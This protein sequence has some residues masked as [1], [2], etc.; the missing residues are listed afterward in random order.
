MKKTMVSTLALVFAAISLG[1]S[2]AP[3]EARPKHKTLAA[4]GARVAPAKPSAGKGRVRDGTR[5][6]RVSE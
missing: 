4:K 3:A 6:P 1:L 2:A 5:I